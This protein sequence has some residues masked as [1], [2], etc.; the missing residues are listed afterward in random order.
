VRKFCW[1]S[2]VPVLTISCVENPF[3]QLKELEFVENDQRI[4]KNTLNCSSMRLR[5]RLWVVLGGYRWRRSRLVSRCHACLPIIFCPFSDSSTDQKYINLIYT[6][7][8]VQFK[9][10]IKFFWCFRWIFLN[11]YTSYTDK[12]PTNDL[13]YQSW[14][15]TFKNY[16]KN[17]K[18]R[19]NMYMFFYL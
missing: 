2:V 17:L 12:I 4:K 9:S 3:H 16:E 5:R 1:I 19:K 14:Q 13:F 10:H 11:L 18:N 15:W 6:L 8:L 7:Y